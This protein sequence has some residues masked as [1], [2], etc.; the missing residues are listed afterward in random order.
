MATIAAARAPM[1]ASERAL[2][3]RPRIVEIARARA[4]R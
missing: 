4:L 2:E 3:N 1:F